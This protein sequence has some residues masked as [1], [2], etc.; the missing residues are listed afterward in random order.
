LSKKESI[1]KILDSL[2][3]NS[4]VP[5]ANELGLDQEGYGEILEIMQQDN[6]IF[7]ANISR[8]GQG[9]KVHMVFTDGTKITIRGIDYLEKNKS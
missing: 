3:E 8:A 6:L 4:K 1:I 9:N 5:P 7:G 2:N